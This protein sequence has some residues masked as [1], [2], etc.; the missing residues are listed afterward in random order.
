MALV[1]PKV[2]E[3]TY[4]SQ[5][6]YRNVISPVMNVAAVTMALITTAMTGPLFD[7]FNRVPS[8]EVAV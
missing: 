3:V 1:S 6:T 7:R 8:E 5:L 2:G 4:A